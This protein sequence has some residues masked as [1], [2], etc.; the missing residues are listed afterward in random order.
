MP[1][2][3][4]LGQSRS[5]RRGFHSVTPQHDKFSQ[6]VRG[7]QTEQF[8]SFHHQRARPGLLDQRHGL[9]KIHVRL[10][11]DEVAIHHARDVGV[12]PFLGEC[13]KQQ[14]AAQQADHLHRMHYREVLLRSGK[15][16]IRCVPNLVPVIQGAEVRNHGG[17]Y[18]DPVG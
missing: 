16:Q 5:L 4:V 18:R 6:V 9:R 10:E 13:S 11:A 2:G 8:V 14:I 12:W 15:Q 7:E 1:L 3:E 17:A